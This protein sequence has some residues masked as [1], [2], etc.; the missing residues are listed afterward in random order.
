MQIKKR[1]RWWD[2]P[3][4]MSL[5][6]K[7]CFFRILEKILKIKMKRKLLIVIKNFNK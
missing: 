4:H 7:D 6:L 3:S 2:N 5:H 1:F